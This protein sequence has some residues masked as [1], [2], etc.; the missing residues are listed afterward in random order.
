MNMCDRFTLFSCILLL[1]SCASNIPLEIREN[2]TEEN[3]TVD[4]ARSDSK[5]FTGHKVRWGGTI[6][7]IQ[8]KAQETWIEIVDRPLG[9]YG[10]PQIND[11]SAGRFL[12]R[13][14]GFLDSAIYKVDRPITVFGTIEES[15]PG[16]I[17][18]YSYNYPTVRATS[19]YLWSEYDPYATYYGYP[20]GYYPYWYYPYPYYFY[21]YRYNFGFRYGYYPHYYFGLH[22][23]FPW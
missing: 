9:S 18:E 16:N 6:A 2:V 3:I 19:H 23:H 13:V 10:R 21:P 7:S 15:V 20:Y 17:G 14:D 5:R 1:C 22:Q 11:Q 12:A 8:N 4:A